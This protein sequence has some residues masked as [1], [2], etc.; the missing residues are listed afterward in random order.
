MSDSLWPH[1]LQHARLPCPSPPPEACSNSCPLSQWC[2]PTTSSSVVPFSSCLPSFPASGSF[3]MSQFFISGGQSIGASASASVLP[4]N[5]QDWF[6]LDCLVWSPYSP[7]DSQVFSSTTVWKHQVNILNKFYSAP[8][9]MLSIRDTLEN[10][11]TMGPV[12][13]VCGVF[14]DEASIWNQ[15]S[16]E[17]LTHFWLYSSPSFFWFPRH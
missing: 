1:G 15:Q 7:S 10:K 11:S 2:H 12:P 4:M 9:S 14:K 13:K 8:G 17:V 5:I 6:L 16:L 3:P